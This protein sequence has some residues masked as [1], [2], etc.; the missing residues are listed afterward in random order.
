MT[1]VRVG[2]GLAPGIVVLVTARLVQGL[3]ARHGRAGLLV[4]APG[5]NPE[6]R[7]RARAF[8]VWGGV[9]GIAAGGGPIAGGLLIAASGWRAVFFINIPI[10]LIGLLAAA[11]Y[12]RAP[13]GHARRLDLAAQAVDIVALAAFTAALI[14]AGRLG[15]TSPVVLD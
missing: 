2:C 1:A 5:R 13:A 9:A 11:R 15:I 4:P 7:A 8:G 10:G 6:R 12:V 3:G 14:E